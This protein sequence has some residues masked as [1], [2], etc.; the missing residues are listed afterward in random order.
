MLA[1][2]VWMPGRD[3]LLKSKVGTV[4]PTRITSLLSN[5]LSRNQSSVRRLSNHYRRSATNAMSGPFHRVGAEDALHDRDQE[6]DCNNTPDNQHQRQAQHQYR[7]EDC[8]RD[9]Q[10]R[11]SHQQ[12]FE[13]PRSRRRVVAMETYYDLAFHAAL[14]IRPKRQEGSMEPAT[15]NPHC[16]Y[17][18]LGQVANNIETQT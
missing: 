16:L 7:H 10:N 4:L 2:I 5:K 18:R 15:L 12:T 3:T 8:E 13:W 6:R 14:S 9:S 11:N 1:G 17:G